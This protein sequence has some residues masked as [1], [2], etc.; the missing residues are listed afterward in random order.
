MARDLPCG[1]GLVSGF[2]G[3]L[4]SVFAVTAAHAEGD[5]SG[6]TATAEAP[7]PPAQGRAT[8]APAPAGNPELVVVADL[9]GAGSTTSAE[10]RAALYAVA[11]GHGYVPAGKLDVV[12]A[13]SRE[14]LVVS[15]SVT[16]DP[17][18][19][20]HLRFVL[21]VPA[22]VRVSRVTDR[23]G[24]TVRITV[25]TEEAYQTR[26]LADDS[27]ES[28]AHALDVLL[29]ARRVVPVASGDAVDPELK[30]QFRARTGFRATY[31]A[32]AFATIT[33]LRHYGFDSANAA[34]TGTV[35]GTANAFGVGGGVGLRA[36]V[37]YLPPLTPNPSGSFFAARFD[38]G[39][40]TD[41]LYLRAPS[42]FSY[43]G[44][45]RNLV[46]GNR[47]LFIGSIPFT[48]GGALA[49]GQF[50]EASWHGVLLGVGYAPELEYA[51]DLARSSGDF[52]FNPA[53]AELSV[54]VTRLDASRG[55]E[56]A[57]Q[58]RIALWG[59]APIDTA[60]PGRLSLGLGAV[61]Y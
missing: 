54:D 23:E 18:K 40:D 4:A 9:G 59:V 29:P 8:P 51:M 53:G 36:G 10:L 34:G 2:L 15:G 6:A 22:L 26:I 21:K 13:A 61:W 32:L 3:V 37:I 12:G 55:N 35:H 52:R 47:A 19:L 57:A 27:N 38:V 17:V 7:T 46:Y 14:S 20:E 33:S 44:S 5:T 30:E 28:I 60:H 48:L 58:I 45:S 25:V 43:D 31:G 41:F 42:K 39:L 49:V 16:D 1:L 50:G 56:S 24:G 11:R